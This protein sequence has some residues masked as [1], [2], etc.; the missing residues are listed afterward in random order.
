M[1]R[2]FGKTGS[3]CDGVM[4][5][6]VRDNTLYVRIDDENRAT[7]EKA[8]SFPPLNYAASASP[9][10]LTPPAPIDLEFSEKVSCGDQLSFLTPAASLYGRLMRIAV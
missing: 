5:G 4:L 10:G 2:M 8:E 7:L 3:F 1:R 9:N 6:M